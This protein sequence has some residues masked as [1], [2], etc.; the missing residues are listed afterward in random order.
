VINFDIP[1]EPEAYIH[2]IGRTGRV[3]RKGIAISFVTEKERAYLKQIESLMNY[4]VPVM[5]LPDGL[6]ISDVLTDDE[7]PKVRMKDV[8]IK[9]PKRNEGGGAFHEKLAKNKKVNVKVSYKDKMMK[10]YGKP[11]TRGQKK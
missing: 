7:K 8:L 4:R 3:G 1:E 10:K 2:R 11:K 6:V 5:E 9:L